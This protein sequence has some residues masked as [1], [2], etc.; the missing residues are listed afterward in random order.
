MG[1]RACMHE[2]GKAGGNY[3]CAH[4]RRRKAGRMEGRKEACIGEGG[5]EAQRAPARNA[6]G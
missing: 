3:D 5:K 6:W 4:G 2:G 1:M